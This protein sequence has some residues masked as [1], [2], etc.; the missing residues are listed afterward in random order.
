MKLRFNLRKLSLLLPALL[1]ASLLL[2][3][4]APL[5]ADA[6]APADY[7]Y[8]GNYHKVKKGE[9]L[10]KLARYYSVTV[11][12]L[13]KANGLYV[14]SH[15]YIG[16][17]LHIPQASGYHSYS[18]CARYHY[19]RK[20]QTLSWIAKHLGVNYHALAKA[21]HISN[22]DHIVAGKKLCIPKIYGHSGYGYGNYHGNNGHN[23]HGYHGNYH[24]VK[25]GET[26]SQIAQRYGVSVY[27]LKS[28]NHIADVD[29]IYY[30]QRLKVS[31]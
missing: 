17:K 22:P 14:N 2:V 29:H 26:L 20:G 3:G 9:S 18:D 4:M 27:H 25:K 8:Y 21:N 5:T 16:Q 15:I 1:I 30:G 23:N 31:W 12:E 28:I 19:V 11:Y 6:A 24:I 7:G 10:S 13:A